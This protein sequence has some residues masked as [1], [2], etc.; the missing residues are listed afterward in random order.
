MTD[1]RSAE[2]GDAMRLLI[3]G[4]SPAHIGGVETFCDRAGAA[5][6]RHDPHVD[7]TRIATG[8]AYLS[9]RTLPL[10][11]RGLSDLARH[12]LGGRGTVWLQY[13]NLPDLGYLLAARMLGFKVI[14][15]PHLG[16]DW[17]SER[18][19]ALR[20]LSRTLLRLA[21]RIALLAR[22]QQEEIALPT[23]VPRSMIRTFLPA[24]VLEPKPASERH[25]GPLRLV[26][27]SR[28][29]EAKGSFLVIDVCAKLRDAGIPFS[30]RIIGSADADTQARL[31]A[32]I[33][34]RQLAREVELVGW[35]PPSAL[36]GH[37]READVLI[38]LSRVD[39][40]PLIVLEALASGMVPVAMDLAGARDMIETYDGAIVGTQSPVDEAAA[41]L[42]RTAPA[43]LRRRGAREADRVRA[44]FAWDEAA[45]Q[46]ATVLRAA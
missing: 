6:R 7:I 13:V 5:L 8:T 2:K 41:Y 1:Q 33:A 31:E 35:T 14:V 9:L 32:M 30:A 20:G 18:V 37:L 4:G 34:D 40:Y 27:A 3:L 29:S 16:K 36:I 11:L 38:H 17:R 25:A 26:H 42:Q 15:T 39:S 45:A 44:D 21:D 43:D 46:L 19:P 24:E 28:L 22:T 12:R 10:V 23:R